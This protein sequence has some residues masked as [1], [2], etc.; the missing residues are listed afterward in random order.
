MDYL[1]VLKDIAGAVIDVQAIDGLLRDRIVLLGLVHYETE[2]VRR[3]IVI[4]AYGER[5]VEERVSAFVSYLTSP[6]SISVLR[7]S[8]TSFSGAWSSP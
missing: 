1:A 7:Q 4:S 8:D 5:G 3:I 2:E 6:S